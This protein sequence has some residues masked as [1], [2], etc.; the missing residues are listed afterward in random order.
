MVFYRES[1]LGAAFR[2]MY[3]ISRDGGVTWG[4]GHVLDT[5]NYEYAG[6]VELSPTTV[7][8]LYAV[9]NP[10]GQDVTNPGRCDVRFV[11]LTITDS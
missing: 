2:S 6:A 10:A 11:T 5:G 7:G 1:Q 4:S 9:D 8:V 3:R